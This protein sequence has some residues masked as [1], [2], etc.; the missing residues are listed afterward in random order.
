MGE[1]D[2]AVPLSEFKGSRSYLFYGPPGTG[3]TWLATKHPG[4]KKIYLDVDERLHELPLSS[5]ERASIIHW[6]PD[7]ILGD[8]QIQIIQVDPTRRDVYKGEKIAHKPEGFVRV[9]DIINELLKLHYEAKKGGPPFPYDCVI[10]DPLTRLIDHLVYLVM[11]KHGVTNMTE[12]LF[13]VE[14]RQLKEA[15]M[16]FLQLPCDRI[17]I[18]HSMH[19][20]KRDKESQAIIW[21]KIQPHI[22]GSDMMRNELVGM[23]TEAYFFTGYKHADKKYYIRTKADRLAQAR[24]AKN[25]EYDQ[26]I[27]PKKI[28]A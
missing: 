28:Y 25:L 24:T 17:V 26:E 5:E 18:A 16:G 4:K 19:K 12:T 11:Y 15:I 21:E 13:A 27:D 3:K 7:V 6:K 2:R 22:Y 9:V 1:L 10:L 23:F 20:E 14:G 8:S